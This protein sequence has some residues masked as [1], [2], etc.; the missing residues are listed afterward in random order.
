[1][2]RGLTSEEAVHWNLLT[3]IYTAGKVFYVDGTNGDDSNSGLLPTD[4]LQTITAALVKCTSGQADVIQIL[5]NS[6]SS[7][8]EAETFPIAVNKANVTI[9]GLLSPRGAILSDSGIGSDEVN[10]A[11]FEIGA[12]YVTIEDMYLGCAAEGTTGGIIEFNGTNSYFG[13]VI[14]R[15]TFDTQYIPALGIYAAYDQPYLLVEDCLFGRSDILAYTTACI[16]LGNGTVVV[17]RRNIFQGFAGIGVSLGA[18][19][20]NT[21][22]LDNRFRLPSDTEGKAITMAEGAKGNF[23]DGN[24]AAFG[25]TA[26]SNNPYLD[27]GGLADN[28]WGRNFSGGIAVMPATS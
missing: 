28:D 16:Y 1:M 10:V 18:G 13:T 25:R 27:S 15:C 19:C 21:T 23:V 22:I 24:S 11:C 7:P 20:G 9:R 17:I 14:R 2:A 12:S 6:P 3:G 26:P 5:A 4:P 8:P